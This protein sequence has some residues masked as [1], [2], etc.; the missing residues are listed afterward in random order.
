MEYVTVTHDVVVD[1][2]VLLIFLPPG[3]VNVGYV[4]CAVLLFAVTETY[5]PVCM[6]SVSSA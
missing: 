4:M 3:D 6:P 5:L 2:A 1:V